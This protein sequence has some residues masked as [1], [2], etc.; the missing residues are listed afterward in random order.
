MSATGIDEAKLEQFMGQAET[1]IGAGM[2]APLTVLGL[3]LGLYKAMAG[4]GPL[5][6]VEVAERAGCDE[7]HVRE[8]R[9]NQVIGGYIRDDPDSDTYELPPERALELGA[10]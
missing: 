8:R 3:K 1:D 9:A 10:G 2:S 6:S 5:T 7:R 4:A